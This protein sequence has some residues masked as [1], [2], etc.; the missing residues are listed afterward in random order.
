MID[1]SSK[2]LLK[3][4]NMSQTIPITMSTLISKDM[5]IILPGGDNSYFKWKGKGKG[6]GK[7]KG[8]I[9]GWYPTTN[10]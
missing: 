1:N 10:A 7:G 4:Y 8:V 2:N 9:I 5:G 6:N 3:K